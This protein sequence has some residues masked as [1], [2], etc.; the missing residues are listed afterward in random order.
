MIRRKAWVAIVCAGALLAGGIGAS[1]WGRSQPNLPTAEARKGEFVDYFQVR[2]EI[3]AENSTIISAPM[4]AGDLQIL[5]LSRNGSVVKKGDVVVQ[6]DTTNL[7][8]TLEQRRAELKSAE[9]DIDR[10]RAQGRLNK[11][12]KITDS[13]KAKYDVERARLDVSKQEILSEIEG[14]KSKLTLADAQQKLQ[15]SEQKVRASDVAANAD[16]ES[17]KQKQRKALFDIRLAERQIASMRVAAPVD[18]IV[19]LSSNFRGRGETEFKEGDRAWA[20]A[21][22]AEIPDLRSIRMTAHVDEIDRGPLK[23]GQAVLIRIDAIPDHEF[24]ATVA[25]ISTIAKPDFSGWPPVKNFDLTIKLAE[26][27]ARVRPGMNG[28]ARIVLDR[29][30]GAVVVPS[31]SLFQ[32]G[33]RTIVYVLR[34]GRLEER[35]V[36]IGKRNRGEAI[37][38]AGLAAGERIALK[39]PTTQEKTQK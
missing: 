29:I 27:D 14:E 15:E 17:K 2:G 11:E 22:I 37:V 24:A 34:R 6:F 5:K 19:T 36:T 18:G 12:Q 32:K 13:L 38:S 4:S 21:K 25:D 8:Q 31:E 16:A 7:N 26:T 23:K 10:T 20:G 9:A 33:G 3:S 1:R 28:N 35:A 39:D 30:Q